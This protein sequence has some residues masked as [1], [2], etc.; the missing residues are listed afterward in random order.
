MASV[1]TPQLAGQPSVEGSTVTFAFT[2]PDPEEGD[3]LVWRVS[4]RTDAEPT[5]KAE[6][7]TVVVS[8]YAPGSTVCITVSVLRAGKT[9]ANPYETCY[10]Q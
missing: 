5:H 3:V 8:D 2:N 10:P 6:G 4:N 9:S 7:D 1:Q